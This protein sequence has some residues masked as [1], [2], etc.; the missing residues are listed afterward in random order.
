MSKTKANKNKPKKDRQRGIQAYYTK[1]IT[2]LAIASF[3][4]NHTGS[5]SI[6]SVLDPSGGIGH[7]LYGI[8]KGFKY[9]TPTLSMIEPFSPYPD[10]FPF[11]NIKRKIGYYQM[12]FEEWCLTY[13]E[14]EQFDLVFVNP[15]FNQRIGLS[16]LGEDLSSLFLPEVEY[17][18]SLFFLASSFIAKSYMAFI[19]PNSYFNKSE[20][21]PVLNFLAQAGWNL[22]DLRALPL[23]ACHNALEEMSLLFFK[24]EQAKDWP[25]LAHT[26]I[27]HNTVQPLFNET[28]KGSH[29]GVHGPKF[30]YLLPKDWGEGKLISLLDTESHFDPAGDYAP[31]PASTFPCQWEPQPKEPGSLWNRKGTVYQLTPHGW[32]PANCD[33]YADGLP[34]SEAFDTAKRAFSFMQRGAIYSAYAMLANIDLQHLKTEYNAIA[35]ASFLTVLK[36]GPMVD[37][38]MVKDLEALG[39]FLCDDGTPTPQHPDVARVGGYLVHKRY[40]SDAQACR[41]YLALPQSD[42]P[43]WVH[44]QAIAATKNQYIPSDKLNLRSPWIPK[45]LIAHCLGWKLNQKG[46][47]VGQNRGLVRYLN[48]GKDGGIITDTDQEIFELASQQFA[49]EMNNHDSP[50]FAEARTKIHAHFLVHNAPKLRVQEAFQ[51]VES[52]LPLHDWQVN[53]VDFYLSGATISNLDVGLG[54]TLTALR[55]AV[56]HCANGAKAL[57]TVPKQVLAKWGATLDRFFPAIRWS[58]LGF[59]ETAKGKL[60]RLPRTELTDQA[61]SVFFDP[62]MQIILTSHQVFGEFQV[63]DS[64]R[65]QADMANAFDQIGADMTATAVKARA[66]FVKQAGRRTYH[67][68][69]EITFSDLPKGLLVVI[70]EAHNYKGLFGMPYSG[71]GESLIMAGNARLKGTH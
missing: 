60:A 62:G 33:G 22:A 29:Q 68:G 50:Q 34:V 54:K 27:K 51:P 63:N 66:V 44:D 26:T 49:I 65:L 47:Y 21:L 64:D 48:Y 39:L 52:A 6:D 23:D 71:W 70:D 11:K 5:K 1:T 13:A 57:I 9:N 3:I 46:L 38:P 42:L 15:P 14:R 59:R 41:L 20:A 30:G 10:D 17:F 18:E 53:D 4:E 32:L 40:L 35:A 58:I 16:D 67:N 24:K 45:P 61:K 25:E 36:K 12:S 2:A 55:A 43:Q 37:E 19:V 56:A 28:E 7:L 8:Q 69:G 31:K